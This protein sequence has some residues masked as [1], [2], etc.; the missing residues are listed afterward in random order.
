[1]LSGMA[2]LRERGMDTAGLGTSSQNAAMLRTA[3]SVGF[4]VT[5]HVY[6]YNKPIHFNAMQNAKTGDQ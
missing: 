2:L 1:M 3:A 6:W 5:K 4:Q